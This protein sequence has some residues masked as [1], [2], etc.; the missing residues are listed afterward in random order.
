VTLS[1]TGGA[2]WDTPSGFF[3][4]Y[5]GDLSVSGNCGNSST[6]R[7]EAGENGVVNLTGFE[8]N[9]PIPLE[10]TG[11][12]TTA[13]ASEVTLYGRSDHTIVVTLDGSTGGTITAT[14]PSGGS[15]YANFTVN[16]NQDRCVYTV[17]NSNCP[18]LINQTLC[19]ACTDSCQQNLNVKLYVQGPPVQQCEVSAQAA[20]TTCAPCAGVAGAL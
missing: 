12:G 15:C 10:P 13:T 17:K 18:S 20:T 4:S 6:A 5:L 7:L 19:L 14:N 9:E 1:L 16:T 3:G 2:T 11:D 8:G